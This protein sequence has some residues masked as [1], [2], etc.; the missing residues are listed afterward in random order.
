MAKTAI[1]DELHITIHVPASLPD[2]LAKTVRRILLGNAFTSRL[3][4]A[5]RGVVRA[6]PELAVV[7]VVIAR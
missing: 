3:K 7:R 1:I 4:W 5:I 2:A 6:Y